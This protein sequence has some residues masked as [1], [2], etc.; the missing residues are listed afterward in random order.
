MFDVNYIKQSSE[1]EIESV[2]VHELAHIKDPSFVS[3]KLNA[4]YSTDFKKF[5]LYTSINLSKDPAD[6]A[7]TFWNTYYLHPFEV[8]AI[9]PEVLGH[10]V[11]T[12][13]QKGYLIGKQKT[14]S[15]L[16]Q[17]ENWAKGVDAPWSQDA[18]D[19]LGYGER[20]DINTFFDAMAKRN[21]A[22]YK[23]LRT[24]IAKQVND[25]KTQINKLSEWISIN[26]VKRIKLKNLL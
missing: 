6:A 1:A 5:P 21:P 23:T 15:A 22:G 12:T 25:L 16:N 2:I 3:P 13:K 4:R 18:A 7:K 24:K 10:M 8:N 11:K 20:A 19:I 26:R 14:L 17:I 9:T